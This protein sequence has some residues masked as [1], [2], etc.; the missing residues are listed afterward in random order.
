MIL[1]F[2]LTALDLNNIDNT[3][4][5]YNNSEENDLLIFY[6]IQIIYKKWKFKKRKR[7]IINSKGKRKNKRRG[8]KENRKE[9]KFKL[10]IKKILNQ[11][12]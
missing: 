11:I 10:Q 5:F 6:F 2:E 8:K 4:N 3:C 9:K 12:Y 7:R 1:F